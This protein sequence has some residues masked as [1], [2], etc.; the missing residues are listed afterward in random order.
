MNFWPARVKATV[1]DR[2]FR[3]AR[4]VGRRAVHA[5]D[6]A[7]GK[8][9]GV[10]LGCLFGRPVKPQAGRDLGHWAFLRRSTLMAGWRRHVGGRE[11]YRDRPPVVASTEGGQPRPRRSTSGARVRNHMAAARPHATMA[12]PSARTPST[13]RRHRLR[14]APRPSNGSAGPR[15]RPNITPPADGRPR[16]RRSTSSPGVGPV[17][18][19]DH[20]PSAFR[21]GGSRD[22]RLTYVLT[23]SMR[24]TKSARQAGASNGLAK[25]SVIRAT[26]PSRSS[27]T[28]T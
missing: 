19:P 13:R 22:G 17:D 16:N 9:R 28:P 20:R 25:Y 3:R 26:L 24:S 7:V 23:G 10:Q 27:P 15:S 11:A 2:P 8:E 1:E 4:I 6:P 14:R 12:R 21:P 5:V 18:Q